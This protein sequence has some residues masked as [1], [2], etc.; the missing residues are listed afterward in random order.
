MDRKSRCMHL[1][2]QMFLAQQVTGS[3]LTCCGEKDLPRT[4]ASAASRLKLIEARTTC[5]TPQ[6]GPAC[7]RPRPVSKPRPRRAAVSLATGAKEEQREHRRR[8]RVCACA[9]AWRSRPGEGLYPPS[10]R[11][12]CK[13]QG[14]CRLVRPRLEC[15]MRAKGS[16]GRGGS[17]RPDPGLGAV[18][19]SVYVS[20]ETWNTVWRPRR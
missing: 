13:G 11:R 3:T 1:L 18:D 17:C 8:V 5:P 9:C 10:E 12:K 16:W 4:T 15:A 14:S 6:P 7:H 20:R 19:L 2:S